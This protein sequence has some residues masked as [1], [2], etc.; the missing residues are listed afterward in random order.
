M[1]KFRFTLEAVGIL[2]KRQEQDALD[3]YGRTLLL[4][5][6]A[7]SQLEMVRQTLAAGWQ[8]L[9][10]LLS[11]GCEAAAVSRMQAY[12]KTLEKRRDE[13]IVALNVAERRVN[14]AF[15][16]LMTAR[17]QREIVDKAFD[18]QTANHVRERAREEQKFLDDLAGR[19]GSSVLSWNPTGA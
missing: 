11:H 2:R 10:E 19:R 1:K 13:C 15:A 16:S 12:H 5:Q 18:K 8:E 4:R 6:Q 17:Q 3:Q 14:A 9:R 7:V